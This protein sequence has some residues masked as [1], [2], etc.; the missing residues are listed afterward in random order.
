MSK[1][2][3]VSSNSA[4]GVVRGMICLSLAIGFEEDRA[5]LGLPVAVDRLRN[6]LVENDLWLPGDDQLLAGV[7]GGD[8]SSE[9]VAETLCSMRRMGLPGGATH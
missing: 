8:I 3:A 2:G 5:R 1:E 6:A 4:D 7:L 9:A